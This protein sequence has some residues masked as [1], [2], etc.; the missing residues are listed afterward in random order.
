MQLQG[1]RYAL[2]FDPI[3][4]ALLPVSSSQQPETIF[5]GE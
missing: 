1:L 3:K 4:A 5:L 2:P